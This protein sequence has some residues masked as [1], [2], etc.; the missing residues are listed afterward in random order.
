MSAH[1]LFL[2]DG[3][4]P[5]LISFI[6]G[7]KSDILYYR[8]IVRYLI[9]SSIYPIFCYIGKISDIYIWNDP[10]EEPAGTLIKEN[11]PINDCSDYRGYSKFEERGGGQ[12]A[13]AAKE[14]IKSIREG[15]KKL[16]T[17]PGR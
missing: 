15:T 3:D 7:F 13:A 9:L 2:F 14:R 16:G 10:L 1:P 12:M 4:R 6:I 5:W 17:L 11:D 8:L